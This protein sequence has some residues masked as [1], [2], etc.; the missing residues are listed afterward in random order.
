[1][2]AHGY[3]A[4]I[5]AN[6]QV[7]PKCRLGASYSYLTIRGQPRTNSIADFFIPTYET[8]FVEGSSP[9]NQFQVHC[10]LDLLKNLQLNTSV[11]YVDTLS[12]INAISSSGDFQ[13]VPSYVRLD[14]N[15]RWQVKQNMTVAVGVQNLLQ[16]RHYEFGSIDSLA[17]P[18]AVPR[19]FFAEWTMTF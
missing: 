12:Y 3:G 9:K 5:S 18:T 16:N 1:M 14:M 8:Q 2:D 19:T 13:R 11:Y 7:T 10:Y 4:E 17:E 6:W 15:L